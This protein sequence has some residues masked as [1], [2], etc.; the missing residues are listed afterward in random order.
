[1]GW[2]CTILHSIPR[3]FCVAAFSFFALTLFRSLSSFFFFLSRAL[4]SFR[5]LAWRFRA[6]EFSRM[7]PKVPGR[8]AGLGM[9]RLRA[10]THRRLRRGRRNEIH[11]VFCKESSSYS[12]F[13]K[14]P[15][16]FSPRSVSLYAGNGRV[17]FQRAMGLPWLGPL[18][19]G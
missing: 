15:R 16:R 13:S 11:L 4:A 18:W 12:H 2:T 6:L 9:L 3:H 14:F 19:P 17:R 8:S 1:M 5:P 7:N 10:Y